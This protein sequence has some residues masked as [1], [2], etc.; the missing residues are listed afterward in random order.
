MATRPASENPFPEILLSEV[1]APAAAPS[2]KVRLYAKADGLP[3]VKDDAGTETPLGGAGSTPDLDDLGDVDTTGAVS[4]DVLTY[5]GADWVAAAPSGG[6]GGTPSAERYHPDNV[7]ATAV[8]VG[9]EYD[10][11]THGSFAWAPSDPATNDVTTYPGHLKA[12]E[13]TTVRFYSKAWTPGASD[14]TAACAIDVA[15]LINSAHV[16]LYVAGATGNTPA[17]G[18]LAQLNV[19]NSG[20]AVQIDCYTIT[21][22]SY[23]AFGSA[24]NVMPAGHPMPRRIYLRIT[25]EVSGP[26]WTVYWSLDGMNWVQYGTTS[27]KSLTVGAIGLRCVTDTGSAT[28]TVP[29]IRGWTSVLE[30]IGA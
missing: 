12:S 5:D 21:G 25:R 3:Y 22:G 4:G 6:G 27:N 18:I 26:T 11:G 17:E 29:F 28:F 14:V 2:G 16:G 20:T 24:Q 7:P 9:H 19:A 1:A 13:N 23:S 30:K 15:T 10:D 8:A